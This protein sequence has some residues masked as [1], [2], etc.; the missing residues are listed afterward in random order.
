MATVHSKHVSKKE[1]HEHGF[2][3]LKSEKSEPPTAE[4]SSQLRKIRP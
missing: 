2:K 1:K 4:S 3:W